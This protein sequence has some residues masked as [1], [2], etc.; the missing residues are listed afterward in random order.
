MK[1]FEYVQW[2]SACSNYQIS[3]SGKKYPT[4]FSAIWNYSDEDFVYFDGIISSIIYD[5]VT[6]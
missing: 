1:G 3:D 6:K 5:E 4:H 2:T